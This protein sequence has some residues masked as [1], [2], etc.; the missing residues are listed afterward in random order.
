MSTYND[1]SSKGCFVYVLFQLGAISRGLTPTSDSA[2]ARVLPTT[3]T[4]VVTPVTA[5]T[6]IDACS[7]AGFSV[8][9]VEYASVR[10][11]TP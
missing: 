11:F 10:R 8:A 9:G 4:N 5:K 7:A 3:A 1:W 6:C 2:A